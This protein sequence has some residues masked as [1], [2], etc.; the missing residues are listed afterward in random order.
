M[1]I[2]VS[3]N[4]Q[5]SDTLLDNEEVPSTFPGHTNL[6]PVS[7]RLIKDGINGC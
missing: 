5:S 3:S 4:D 7:N 2:D 1:D 6:L